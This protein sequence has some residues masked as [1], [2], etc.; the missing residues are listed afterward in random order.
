MK[1]DIFCFNTLIWCIF[2]KDLS[3]HKAT[4]NPTLTMKKNVENTN[5]VK[6]VLN[7]EVTNDNIKNYTASK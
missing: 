3:A 6:G 4:A 2:H 1:Q 5:C 7:V